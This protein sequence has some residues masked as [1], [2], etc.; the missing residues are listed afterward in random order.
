MIV[1]S[2]ADERELQRRTPDFRLIE[3]PK[4]VLNR[5]GTRGFVKWSAG[6][7]GGTMRVRLVNGKWLIDEL[8]SWIT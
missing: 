1:Y 5:A 7:T 4:I 2:D 6:W 3:L 8:E